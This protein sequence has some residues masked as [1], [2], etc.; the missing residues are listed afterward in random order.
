MLAGAW[1]LCTA[2]FSLLLGGLL[3]VLTLDGGDVAARWFWP[4]VVALLVLAV[5]S[6]LTWRVLARR[7]STRPLCITGAATALLGAFT[8]LLCN[9][10][11]G[12]VIPPWPARGLHGVAPDAWAKAFS[13]V[14]RDG[15]DVGFNSFG[16]RD[17]ARETR[18]TRAGRVVL[19][20]DSFLEEGGARPLNLAMEDRVGG[21]ELEVLNL[22]VSATAPDEYFYRTR[23]IALP[24]GATHV[25]MFIYA[26]ND[27]I[28]K[29]TLRSFM[30]IT[31]T[32]PRDSL[33]SVFGLQALA[34]VSMNWRRPLLGA[35][36]SAGQ[37]LD[38]ERNLHGELIRSTPAQLVD[39]FTTHVEES[40]RPVL[41]ARLEQPGAQVFF[42]M[43]KNPDGGNFR[44]YFIWP[45][46][47]AAA[48]MSPPPVNGEDF[49]AL[50]VQRTGALCK[51][52]GVRFTAVLVP[53]A[54]SV[55]D[56]MVEQ[57]A[58]VA[59]LREWTRPKA[60]A[61]QRLGR[62]VAGLGLDV[63]DLF[64]VLRGT[65]G[66]YLNMDGHWSPSGVDLVASALV[67]RL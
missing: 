58:G 34:H 21:K 59:D 26:G 65:R 11:A 36:G 47:E 13:G 44:S 46:L 8:L 15:P 64:G 53:E 3:V 29:R 2:A 37:E 61:L 17:R 27:F 10:A 9:V 32:Y 63:V 24:L 51:A 40:R 49:T 50:W 54:F 6:V 22:G 30:G 57:Y 41:R 31:A 48:G 4:Q 55:D 16:Q 33:L 14:K 7:G 35:W 43:L 66:S 52:S 42:E 45:A 28:E 18:P 23:N 67:Q 5:A 19:V 25:M 39:R 56:R 62:T 60:E 20:G 38:A 12:L 1:M